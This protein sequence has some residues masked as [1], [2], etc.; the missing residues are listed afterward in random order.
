MVVEM[1]PESVDV[2]E[3]REAWTEFLDHRRHMGKPL[4]A[5]A[6]RRQLDHLATLGPTRA[7]AAIHHSVANGWQ[8]IYEPQEDTRPSH[9]D[10]AKADR[11]LRFFPENLRL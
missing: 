1:I 8:G 11:K 7:V 9:K 2:P 4:T 5:Q 6:V 10:K 3:F